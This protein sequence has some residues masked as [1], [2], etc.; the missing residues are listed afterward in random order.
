M[1]MT[2][3]RTFLTLSE[4]LVAKSRLEASDIPCALADENAYLYGGAP[5]AMPIRILVPEEFIRRAERLLDADDDSDLAEPEVIDDKPARRESRNPWE[6][7]VVALVF[8]GP[9]LALL[10]RVRPVVLVFGLARKSNPVLSASEAHL[11]GIVLITVA[12]AIAFFYYQLRSSLRREDPAST[13]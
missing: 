2:T 10:L 8:F 7:L 11:L 5:F 13:D 6:I 4:A 9:G 3:L 1:P 12:A